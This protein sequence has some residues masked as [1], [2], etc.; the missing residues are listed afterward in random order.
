MLLCALAQPTINQRNRVR[1][2]IALATVNISSSCKCTIQTKW[3]P[4][5]SNHPPQ[6]YYWSKTPQGIFKLCSVQRSHADY[7][8][9]THLIKS[10]Q[11]TETRETASSSLSCSYTVKLPHQYVFILL[12]ALQPGSSSAASLSDHGGGT[13]QHC[14]VGE[15]SWPL[16]DLGMYIQRI[17]VYFFSPWLL[18]D[19]WAAQD[20]KSRIILRWIKKDFHYHNPVD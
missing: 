5:H 13:R 19:I 20:C 18:T 3:G 9:T 12:S 15:P 14:F 1:V 2:C 11:T 6:C 16:A 7:F 8:S 4:T 17:L 10:S